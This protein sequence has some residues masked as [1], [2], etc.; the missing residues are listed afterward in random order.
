RHIA[1]GSRLSSDSRGQPAGNNGS[2]AV[3]DILGREVFIPSRI[4]RVA[5]LRAGALRLLVY[6]DLADRIAGV[7]QNEK[8]GSTP[9]MK[10]HPELAQLPSLG[11]SMGGDAE[12]ILKSKPDLIF[13]T[14]TTAGDADALQ[15][16][17]GIP[18]IALECTEFGT[19]R[20]TLFA[21]L[22]L[23]GKIMDRSGRADT[24]IN[25][26]ENS[27]AELN[28]RS[29]GTAES[30][31]PLVYI[32]GVGYSGSYGINSTQP[33]FPP[34]MF[35]NARSPASEIDKRLISHVKGTHIDT[36]QL[37]LWNPDILFIDESG[38]NL[39]KQDLRRGTALFNR[40]KAVEENRM[41]TLLPYNNYATNYE[42]VLAN[43]WFAGKI[44]YPEKFSDIDADE[45]TKEVYRIF[46]GRDI[47]DEIKPSSSA[48]RNISKNEL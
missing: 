31:K 16:K 19:A 10:A 8:R 6:M 34:F 7:E 11:P 13:L 27:I 32:G 40:L 20:D 35:L 43:A 29:S 46:L 17:T 18:V 1:A 36:E 41:Y 37:M 22:K 47:S 2:V 48:F 44:L 33:F 28:R 15:Q 23:I 42:M 4:N 39:V 9:Y 3:R 26:I 25:Y 38:L 12:L 30:E 5:G 21:S 45:K 14:Y 24:L